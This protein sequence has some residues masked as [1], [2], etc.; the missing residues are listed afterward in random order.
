MK[1]IITWFVTNSVATN[2]LV[3]FAVIAGVAA[4]SQIPIRAYP[5]FD[6]PIVSITVPY[7][8]AAPEEV[9]RG[10]CTRIEDQVDGVVGIQEVLSTADEGVCT[11]RVEL[12]QDADRTQALN[13]IRNRVNAIETFPA[14][15]EAPLVRL[16]EVPPVVIEV[17]VTGPTDERLLKQA[18]REVRADILALPGITQASVAS[19]RPY[20]IAIEVSEDSLLRNELTFDQ[21]AAA[22]S[23]NSVDLPGGTIKAEQGQVLLRTKGQAY[24]AD[25]LKRIIVKA[26]P[27]GGRVLLEDVAS[28]IDGFEDTGQ[29]FVFDGAPAALVQVSRVGDQDIRQ[30]ADA[31]RGYVEDFETRQHEGGEAVRLTVWNDQSSML[32]DRL[33][34]L[35]GSGIGGLLLV[36]V[37]LALFLRPSVAIWVA[38]GIPIA[39]LGATF[40]LFVVGVSINLYS[41]IGFILVLGMLVDDAVVVGE[42]AYVSHRTGSGQL[43]GVI[44]GTERVLVPVSFGVLT[45]VAAFLPMLYVTGTAGTALSNVGAVV[46]CCLALSL[47]ECLFVLPAHLGHRSDS[48]PFGEFGMVLVAILVLGAF[49]LAPSLR[50][51]V[52]LGIA[53]VGLVW[54][55]QL[56]GGLQRLAGAFTRIQMRFE[57]AFDEFA[58]G[59][60]RRTVR[61]TLQRP[62]LTITAGVA[63]VLVTLAVLASGRLPFSLLTPVYGDRITAEL[64]M[65]FGV[66]NTVTEQAIARLRTAAADVASRLEAAHGE[67]LVVHIAEIYGSTSAA[68][69]AAAAASQASS[70]LGAVV[71]QLT[72]AE[73]R[74]ATALDIAADWRE[75][76]GLIDGAESLVFDADVSATRG[77]DIELRLSGDNVADLRAMAAD[78]VAEIE[79]YPGVV[80]VGDTYLAG[81]RELLIELTPVGHALG[82]TLT[83][84]GRQV[85]QAFYGEEAQRVQRGEDDV[86]IMVRYPEPARRSLA[87]LQSLRIR[88]G[89]G[90]EVPFRTVATVEWGQGPSIITRVSGE[91][92]VTVQADLNV[93]QT[94]ADRIRTA[95]QAPIDQA[96][97]TYPGISHSFESA[98]ATRESL[99][100]AG[101]LFLLALFAMFTLLAIPLRS[102]GQPLI[103]LSV[104]PFC[105]VGAVAG[106]LLLG[107]VPG[108]VVGLSMPSLMGMVAAVGVAVNATLV[109]L[110]SVNHF[111]AGGDAE[112]KALE[113]AAVVRCRPILITTATTLAGLTP[114]ILNTS[115]SIAPMRPIVVSLAFGVATAAAAALLFVPAFCLVL[116]RTGSR[117]KESVAVGFGNLVGRAPRLKR[118]MESYPYVVES[119]ASQ[120]F[121]DLVVE[122]EDLDPE[123]ARIARAGL[124]RLYY[125]REFDRSAMDEQLAAM[126]ERVPTTDEEVAEVRSWTQQRAFQL[127]THMLRSAITPREA[128]E[129]LSSILD[130]AVTALL[131]A[132]RRDTASEFGDLPSGRLALVALD[133]VGR[134]ETVLGSPLRMLFLYDCDVVPADVALTPQQWHE[135]LLQRFMRLAGELSPSG[136]LFEARDPHRLGVEAGANDPSAAHA[137]AAIEEL[138]AGAPTWRDLRTLV[139]ARVIFADDELEERFDAARLG[140]IAQPRDAGLVVRELAAHRAVQAGGAWDVREFPGGLS[141]MVLAAEAI[142]LANASSTPD[143][144]ATGLVPTFEAANRAGVID[145]A[146]AGE[147]TEATILWQNV[148][149]F[150]SLV[151]PDQFDPSNASPEH[152]QAL[153]EIC[154][155]SDF[156]D[157][158]EMVATHSRRA[159]TGL[160]NLFRGA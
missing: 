49:T 147:L 92:T 54:A 126:A 148:Q 41:I 77:H 39:L 67:P 136:M 38:V 2:L 84:L 18:A 113:N 135:R 53:A 121:T 61:A 109:L 91:R 123:T 66:D 128:A 106:H 152:R 11:V 89:D 117:A 33:G 8:G 101:P 156:G 125:R 19:V 97:A 32:R 31:V 105:L 104:L 120:E 81:K 73:E 80:D 130:A 144:M 7:L 76:V 107:L 153:A 35:M 139:H 69:S 82:L 17:A 131:H 71:M 64:T 24:S 20:E 99:A 36:L 132:A 90:A 79:Q 112:A 16:L 58:E 143:V 138:C 25:E 78:L 155:A 15:A 59:S 140:A 34:A 88:T 134:R 62:A 70:H 83:D 13:D 44:A 102:Y 30:I 149:G 29:R 75:T 65:P 137:I 23:R 52:A 46:I 158:A 157:L 10:V 4:F 72:P 68:P 63:T 150:A 133:A 21:V 116:G 146:T 5:D 110:H 115:A 1:R 12:F 47:V 85:R 9:E 37:I 118:W 111:R 60:F 95:L 96:L 98:Q 26:R 93:E 124:V 48:L 151:S 42:A 145:T 127:A 45:T 87:S 14:E 50:S 94:S 6:L 160:D 119:L 154:G 55:A 22:V 103:I 43:A 100:T 129:P 56:W 3:G 122:D 141:D 86:R 142:Q 27:D 114:L 57:Q 51:G 28:V 40:L 108:S 74:P 159:A